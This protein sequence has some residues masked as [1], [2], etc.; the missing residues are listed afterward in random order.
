M[1]NWNSC[2]RAQNCGCSA[3]KRPKNFNLPFIWSKNRLICI[4]RPAWFQFT[5]RE[6]SIYRP[7]MIS[8]YR[9]KFQFTT[10]LV[11]ASQISIYHEIQFTDSNYHPRFQFTMRAY[12]SSHSQFTMRL[13]FSVPGF[14]LPETNY[15]PCFN[16]PEIQ[17]TAPDFNLLWDPTHSPRMVS[18]YHHDINLLSQI[19]IYWR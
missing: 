11:I 1:G 2:S 14:N 8:I 4:Y 3:A 13:L 18:I 15:V 10:R 16:L 17:F 6:I 19:S 7:I 9:P 12:L 5:I